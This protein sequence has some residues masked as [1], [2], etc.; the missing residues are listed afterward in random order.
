M[1]KLLLWVLAIGGV[2]AF[3]IVTPSFGALK[4]AA[5]GISLAVANTWTA[6]QTFNVA[7]AIDAAG[8][9]R[10]TAAGTFASGLGVEIAYTGGVGYVISYNRTG[11]SYDDLNIE[12]NPL[13]LNVGSAHN[14]AVGGQFALYSRTAAQLAA[15]APAAA[16]YMAFNSTNNRVCVSSGTG[17][18]AWVDVTDGSTACD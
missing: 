7:P 13:Q 14:V 6:A 4:V 8:T 9:I 16:G 12:G 15:L 11:G 3:E 1:K 17:A 5:N 18:G 10:A 2:A